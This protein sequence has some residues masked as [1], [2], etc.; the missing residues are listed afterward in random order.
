[1]GND[2]L[3]AVCNVKWEKVEGDEPPI[4]T[5]VAFF[6]DSKRT[7]SLIRLFTDYPY[8]DVAHIRKGI[9]RIRLGWEGRGTA[10][11]IHKVITDL[12]ETGESLA[13]PPR[14]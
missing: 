7:E 2:R 6:S 8:A 12:L 5:I 1:V 3:E 14:P 10:T 13:D 11:E 9:G 4:E